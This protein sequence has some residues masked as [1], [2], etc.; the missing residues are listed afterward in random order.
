MLITL[1]PGG[2]N[3]RVDLFL[4]RAWGGQPKGHERIVIEVKVSRTDLRNELKNPHKLEQ[5]RQYAHRPYFATPKDLIKGTDT[6]PEG[7]G[8][9]EVERE[10]GALKVSQRKGQSQTTK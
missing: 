6:L 9:L 8:I 7:V 2:R 3:G 1:V 4:V 5:H 10:S